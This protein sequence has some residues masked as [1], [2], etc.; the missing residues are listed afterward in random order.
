MAWF[1]CGSGGGS[2]GGG[3]GGGMQTA[4]NQASF[5]HVKVSVT[6]FFL[7]KTLISFVFDMLAVFLKVFLK[8]IAN[9]LSLKP[10]W[11]L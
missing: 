8:D 7:T 4:L 9:T 3:G 1:A 2:G 5:N 11:G 6:P 10:L